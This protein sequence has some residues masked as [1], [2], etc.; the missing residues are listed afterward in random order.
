MLQVQLALATKF[1]DN[2]FDSAEKV[3]SQCLRDPQFSDAHLIMAQI[4]LYQENFRGAL[5]SLEQAVASG[6]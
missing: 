3:L 1:L 5:N 2:D 6:L 4:S